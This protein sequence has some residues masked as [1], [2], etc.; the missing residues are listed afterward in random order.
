M[1]SSNKSTNN[2]FK[3]APGSAVRY[4]IAGGDAMVMDFEAKQKLWFPKNC[5]FFII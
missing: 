4:F 1:D 3:V 5:F 2:T